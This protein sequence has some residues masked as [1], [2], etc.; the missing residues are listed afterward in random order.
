MH[1]PTIPYLPSVAPP[2]SVYEEVPQAHVTPSIAPSQAQTPI[3]VPPPAQLD[4]PLTPQSTFIPPPVQSPAHAPITVVPSA[5]YSGP[6]DLDLADA[7]R[8]R[9]ERF[10]GLAHQMVE[11]MQT[12]EDAENERERTFRV[13]EDERQRMYMDREARRD[14]ESMQH[15]QEILRD[16]EDRVE[17]VLASVPTTTAP[18]PVPPP[19]GPGPSMPIP[20]PYVPPTEEQFQDIPMVPPPPQPRYSPSITPTPSLPQEPEHIDVDAHTLAQSI[21]EQVAEATALHAQDILETVRLEREELAATRAEMERLQTELNAERE[22]RLEEMTVQNNTLREEMAALRAEND[23]LKNDLEEERQL[24]ITEDA[25]RRETEREQDIQRSEGLAT[26]LSDVT[27]IV[28][29]TRD[30]LARKREQADERWAQKETWHQDCNTQMDDMKQMLMGFQRMF[31]EEQELR[32][33]E[34]EAAAAKP[35]EYCMTTS[36]ELSNPSS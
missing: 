28:S 4:R 21:Q 31:Q 1:Q 17:E 18:L 25:A 33:A 26:Q 9:A 13:N 12:A 19:G 6:L 35:S 29:E 24:R 30:E 22:R 16:V 15:R 7:E 34:R 8:E 27:N 20:E 2:R 14:E 10:S 5:Q 36:S 3:P 11:Q 23:R 32:Q